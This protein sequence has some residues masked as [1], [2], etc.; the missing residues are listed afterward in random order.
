MISETE[1]ISHSCSTATSPILKQEQFKD[2]KTSQNRF[3]TPIRSQNY[4]QIVV[5]FASSRL[6]R[7]MYDSSFLWYRT[8]LWI[9]LFLEASSTSLVSSV[10][11][12]RLSSRM[13]LNS[14]RSF[15]SS[16]ST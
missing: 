16:D 7:L 14:F 9:L 12:C 1:F 13:A 11:R 15:S 6:R 5:P 8:S 2:N 3:N 4:F 10:H